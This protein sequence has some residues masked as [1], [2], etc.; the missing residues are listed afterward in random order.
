MYNVIGMHCSMYRIIYIYM[1]IHTHVY[2]YDPR[3]QQRKRQRLPEVDELSASIDKNTADSTE[4]GE[5]G[6]G[7]M[8]SAL[9]GSLR[10]P[11][12][13][14]RGTFWVLPLTYF[15]LPKSANT[16]L[17]PPICQNVHYLFAAAPLVLTPFVRNQGNKLILLLKSSKWF[18]VGRPH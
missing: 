3:Q 9:M 17:F 5:L 14:D 18:P 8:G 7:L 6:K 15:C 1:T 16:Y 2:T 13:F 12:L 10:I 11:C 4:L